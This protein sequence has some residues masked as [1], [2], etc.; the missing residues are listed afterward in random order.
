M[1]SVVV[2][3]R[4]GRIMLDNLKTVLN[5]WGKFSAPLAIY[6][7]FGV[8]FLLAGFIS[9]LRV[10]QW[11][12]TQTGEKTEKLEHL[13]VKIGTFAF[14]YVIPAASVVAAL[15][16]E[17]DYRARYGIIEKIELP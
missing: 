7:V 3:K 8:I 2:F 1:G 4:E 11:I 6:G 17:Q 5:K 16:Y 12:K 10:R 14:L 9:L 13:M 15:V